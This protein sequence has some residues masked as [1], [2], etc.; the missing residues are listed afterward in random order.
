M[1]EKLYNNVERWL[2]IRPVRPRRRTSDSAIEP[3]RIE[4]RREPVGKKCPLFR[5]PMAFLQPSNFVVLN[6]VK[7]LP[8]ET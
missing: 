8:R 2:N 7:A 4:T 6:A 5:L 3:D 1:L